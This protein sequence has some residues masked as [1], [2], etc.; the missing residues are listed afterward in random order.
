MGPCS[1]T[2]NAK[3]TIQLTALTVSIVSY[4]VGLVSANGRANDANKRHPYE[5]VVVRD[6][7][8]GWPVCPRLARVITASVIIPIAPT[9]SRCSAEGVLNRPTD[10]VPIA[11]NPNG[12]KPYAK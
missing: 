2:N 1:K 10:A 4:Q 6:D 5:N 8:S 12:T 3:V 9:V 11:T 7:V